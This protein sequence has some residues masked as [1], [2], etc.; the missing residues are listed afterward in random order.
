MQVWH[1]DRETRKGQLKN[2]TENRSLEDR[3]THLLSMFEVSF[4]ARQ[5]KNYLF[6]CLYYLFEYGSESI[7]EYA[8]FVEELAERYFQSVYLDG[9]LKH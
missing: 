9:T 6:Y 3:L 8:R 7:S 4:T 1:K 5:R 2:L